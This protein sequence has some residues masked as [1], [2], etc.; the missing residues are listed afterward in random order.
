MRD[1]PG[2][3]LQ[4]VHPLQLPGLFPIPVDDLAFPFIEGETLQ[5]EKRSDHVFAHP[6]GLS[7]CLGPDPAVDIEPCVTPGKKAFFPFGTEEVSLDQR[8]KNLAS[9]E[10]CQA[11]V[12]DGGDHTPATAG[13][14]PQETGQGCGSDRIAQ[15][16]GKGSGSKDR[17]RLEKVKRSY[18]A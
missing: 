3:E 10:I 8:P 4:V 9:E 11:R 14:W 12:I 15:K 6:L 17:I 7:L 2:D 5:G 18:K 13:E 1:D 16:K